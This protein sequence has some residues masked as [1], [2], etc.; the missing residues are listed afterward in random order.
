MHEDRWE[1][2]VRE[3]EIENSRLL[4]LLFKLG[5]YKDLEEH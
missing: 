5:K 1:P 2:N 3:K 4:L